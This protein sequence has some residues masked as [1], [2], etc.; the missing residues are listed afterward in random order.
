MATKFRDALDKKGAESDMFTFYKIDRNIEIRT[1]STNF[2]PDN[3]NALRKKARKLILDTYRDYLNIFSKAE[4]DKFLKLRGA[5]N[6]LIYLQN[7][8]GQELLGFAPLYK[9]I[10]EKLL[11]ARK[12]VL[13]N[14]AKGFIKPSSAAFAVPILFARKANGKL[15]FCVNY[16]RLNALIKRD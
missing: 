1:E 6:Y 9:L 10:L 4:S 11:E 2:L 14:L 15:R 7:G 5:G 13:E 16:Q 3:K 12:Y 8:K